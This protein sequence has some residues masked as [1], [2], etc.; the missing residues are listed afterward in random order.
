MVFLQKF[1]SLSLEREVISY[2][3]EIKNSNLRD[4]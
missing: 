2:V 3:F 1:P 4:L